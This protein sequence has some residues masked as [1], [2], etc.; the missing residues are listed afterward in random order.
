MIDALVYLVILV[1]VVGAAIYLVPLAAKRI[2][3]RDEL[4]SGWLHDHVD[5]ERKDPKRS[6]PSRYERREPETEEDS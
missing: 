1:L 6:H 5:R 4:R 2:S 3:E